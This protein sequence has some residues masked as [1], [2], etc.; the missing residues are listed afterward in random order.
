MTELRS[1]SDSPV[2]LPGAAGPLLILQV[3]TLAQSWRFFSAADGFSGL[4]IHEE[5]HLVDSVNVC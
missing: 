5:I 4:I 1:D 3:S 2:I